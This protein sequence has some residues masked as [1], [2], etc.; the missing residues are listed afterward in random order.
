[1]V[2]VVSSLNQSALSPVK[3]VD[4]TIPQHISISEAAGRLSVSDDTV[5][6]L[7]KKG[8]IPAI[9][10]GAQYRIDETRLT[11]QLS[12]QHQKK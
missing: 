4:M 12:H 7:I 11:L 10:V 1:M 9:K 6:R 5:R 2:T 8:S 3:G